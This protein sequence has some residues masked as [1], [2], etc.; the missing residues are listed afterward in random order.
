G[1]PRGERLYHTEQKEKETC[2][3]GHVQIET[4]ETVHKDRNEHTQQGQSHP[5]LLP[6]RTRSQ[7][8]T[9]KNR[10]RHDQQIKEQGRY[11]TLHR[12]FK[13]FIVYVG[14]SLPFLRVPTLL[15]FRPM[16]GRLPDIT[17]GTVSGP[18]PIQD[19]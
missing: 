15:V 18:R 2:G 16:H 14:V 13:D 9:G 8:Q 19:H 3:Y 17:L 1:S 7:T 6:S 10:I 4:K 5:P 11:A 12:G